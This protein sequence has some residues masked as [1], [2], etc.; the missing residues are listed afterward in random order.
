VLDQ[1][2][3]IAQVNTLFSNTIVTRANQL[4]IR[5]FANASSP[6][7]FSSI[8]C[9]WMTENSLSRENSKGRNRTRWSFRVMG[10]HCSVSSYMVSHN[11]QH[12]KPKSSR[13]TACVVYY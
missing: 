9:S 10:E 12:M 13:H 8:F 2:C 7:L 11:C 1:N 6:L 5:G 3:F 4:W